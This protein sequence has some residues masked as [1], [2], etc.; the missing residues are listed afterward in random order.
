MQLALALGWTRAWSGLQ[1]DISVGVSKADRGG[2]HQPMRLIRK[3][4]G[5]YL[6][7]LR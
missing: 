1:R 4:F 3:K 5:A 2:S 7:H 6:V